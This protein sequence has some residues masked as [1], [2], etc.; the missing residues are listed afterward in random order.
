M[1]TSVRLK[2]DD[3]PTIIT[4]LVNAPIQTSGFHFSAFQL[5]IRERSIGVE[6]P[7]PLNLE[8]HPREDM[9]TEA[10]RRA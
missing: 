4:N 5:D 1:S 2:T 9:E 6:S 8:K 7:R 10:G 3:N